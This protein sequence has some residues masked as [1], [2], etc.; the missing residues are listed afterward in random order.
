MQVSATNGNPG[1][2]PPWI[3]PTLPEVA[4]PAAATQ[5]T[6]NPGIVPPWLRDDIHIL[7]VQ[8]GAAFVSASTST[9]PMSLVTALHGIR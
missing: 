4:A 8:T 2:V 7:P 3:T 6:R 5:P 9:S 1:I